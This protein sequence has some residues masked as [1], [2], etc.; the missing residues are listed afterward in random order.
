LS[1]PNLFGAYSA[2]S[3][4]DALVGSS[5]IAGVP[6]IP[7]VYTIT[8]VQTA[9]ATSV[10]SNAAAGHS[11]TDFQGPPYNTTS[12]K[13]PLASSYAA[14]TPSNGTGALGQITVDGVS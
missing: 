1:N 14:I 4:N 2:V 9:T 5:G 11:I 8:K 7:G 10:T 6:A 12:D 3:S 13:V